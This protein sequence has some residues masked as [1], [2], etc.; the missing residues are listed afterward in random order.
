MAGSG[1][2]VLITGGS[3]GIGFAAATLLARSGYR[4]TI[5]SRS[6]DGAQAAAERIREFVPGA[7]ARGVALEL[8]SLEAVRSFAARLVDEGQP[9]HVVIANAAQWPQGRQPVLTVDGYEQLFATNHL[10]HVLLVTRL[11]PLLRASAQATGEARVVVVSSRLH[12]PGSMGPDPRFNF[13]DLDLQGAFDPLVAYKHS[14]LANIWFAYELNRRVAGDGI[15]ANALCPGFVPETEAER[16]RGIKRWLFNHVM[17]RLPF[18]TP[19]HVAAATYLYVATDP[20]LRGVGGK[21]Y[22]EDREIASSAE[23]YDERKAQRLW[24]MCQAIVEAQRVAPASGA[25]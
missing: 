7:A 2:H 4:V 10:G 18:A 16:S 13:D 11:L 5:T 6:V 22:A 17:P 23:S 8:A 21:F 1:K 20:S 19:L 14:K 12:L 15:T 25:Q 3:R 24:E 9:L